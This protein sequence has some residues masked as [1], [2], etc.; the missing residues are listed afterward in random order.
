M[1]D[2]AHSNEKNK[3]QTMDEHLNN[4]G[5]LAAMYSKEFGA[6]QIGKIKIRF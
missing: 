6:E 1:D 3:L 2:Y 5:K 4:V